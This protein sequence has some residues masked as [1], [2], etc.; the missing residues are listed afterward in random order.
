M[1]GRAVADSPAALLTILYL[2]L[3]AGV[4]MTD[5]GLLA[6]L[7]PAIQRSFDTGDAALGALHGVAGILAASA[8]A[9]PLARLADRHSR[10]AVL[11]AFI[12]A[13]AALT[14]LGA[15][16]TWFP[17]FFLGRAA[18]GVTEFALIPVIYSLLPDL[19][20]PRRRVAANLTF[21]ALMAVGAA[22]GYALGGV[23]LG[24]A[25]A[26]RGAWPVPFGGLEPWR[27]A[28]LIAAAAG[29]P[30]LLLGLATVDPPRRHAAAAV[31]S[32]TALTLPGHLRRRGDVILLLVLAAGGVAVA[33][34]GLMP[35]LALALT[36]RFTFELRAL[37]DWL[38][39]IV[40]ATSLASL[41]V[42]GLLDRMLPDAWRVRG[43]PVTMAAGAALAWPCVLALPWARSV[44]DVLVLVTGFLLAT[45]IANAYIPTMVQDLVP[46]AL[47]ARGFAFYSLIIASFSALG[48]V[49]MGAV[50]DHLT[51]RDLLGAMTWVAGPSL[52]LSVICATLSVRRYR[53]T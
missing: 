30:L 29:L 20:G 52:A 31:A 27:L 9:I 39:I 33:V 47:R 45:C 49:L 40:L 17:L 26:L 50:S 44:E 51:G 41:G 48:P 6:I 19:V 12:G 11:L 24:W 46:D 14:A 21:A 5:R 8:L 4:Q 16:A 10:K 34:M 15:L 22:A 28:M 35:L 37:G 2:G 1:A 3:A 13:W 25:E 38:G 23:L 43:R 42:T 7:S 32:A 36:R 18:A 53:E